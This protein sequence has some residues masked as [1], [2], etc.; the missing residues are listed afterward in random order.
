M[1]M[2]L[3]R[4][5]D[6]CAIVSFRWAFAVFLLCC[7]IGGNA[8][9]PDQQKTQPYQKEQSRQQQQQQKQQPQQH[10]KQHQKQRYEI[11][12]QQTRQLKTPLELFKSEDVR[13]LPGIFKDAEQTDLKYMLAMEPDRLL[14]P[15]LR[16]AA[17]TPKAASYPNWEN[18]GLDGHMGGHYLTALSLMYAATGDK[19]IGARINYM[20]SE[21]KRCQDKNGN[22]YIGG[23]PGGN[24]LW[25][26]VANG[27]I[28]A[29]TF[30]LNKKW[31]PLYNI[32]KIYGGLRDVYLY[33]GNLEAKAMLV[34]YSD[35]FLWLTAKLS[36]QQV[37]Q[38]LSSEH[39]GLNEVFADVYAITGNKK[40]L[41]LAYKF[42][43]HAILEP[44]AAGKD[45]LNGM[46]A[47]TQIPKIIGFKRIAD[48]NKDSLY[49]AAAKF[50]WQ[51]VVNN[52]SVANG[53]NSVREHF[54]PANDFSSMISSVEGPETC[55]SYN[56]L[57]LT[58]LFYT[59][60][61]LP[62]YVDYYERTLYNHILSTQHPGDGG[63]VYFTPMRPG[64][65]RVYSQPQTSFWCCVGSG[66]EN[67]GKYNELIYAHHQDNLYLNLF[68]PSSLI[69][70]EK[71][72]TVAQ[73]T[74][75]PE[76]DQTTFTVVNGK[77]VRFTLNVRY[78]S[79]VAGGALQLVLNGKNVKVN[80]QPGAYATITRIW[81]KGD[82][83][84]VILPMQTRTEQLP[85]S[86]KYVAVMHGPVL[87][88]AKTD[89]ADL[90]GLYAD[91]SRMGHI[92]KGKQYPLQDMPLFVT[93]DKAIA[94]HIQAIPDKKLSYSAASLIYPA[95]YKNLELIPFYKIHD[96][97]YVV[98]WQQESTA[99]L[100]QMRKVQAA[101]EQ[102]KER[103]NAMTVDLVYPGEQQPE[104]DHFVQSEQ[105]TNGTYKDRHWRAAKGWFSYEL[106]NK[107]QRANT[108]RITYYGED[109]NRQFK[110]LLNDSE[111][112]TVT[113]DGS[114]GDVFYNQDYVIPKNLLTSAGPKMTV[115]FVAENGA[116]TAG[117]YEVRLIK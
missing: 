62:S 23:V 30:D 60:D 63:F 104:S 19:R 74:N 71:G 82:R 110:I 112:A 102:A 11:C 99:G 59:S 53:G 96:S 41:A 45:Q 107:G 4:N 80:A 50:F 57:K 34:K 21:L 48:L 61:G 16:E 68:I 76:T 103:L 69:W 79:W 98:Y 109:K 90:T 46:H 73:Q 108:L 35:W 20:L 36:D 83:V 77:A 22:G 86:S 117:I 10:Q 64:H 29:G 113:L 25:N 66:L 18:T 13:L 89:T 75:F 27:K 116:E 26:D 72:I 81:K 88:A 67:H 39:G 9:D 78:P 38:M 114:K 12:Q 6:L 84:Q 49:N 54:N 28:Q 97:R 17:L 5:R 101:E 95:R 70:K 111:I 8:Q 40:Y 7:N 55:N 85:D 51:T 33:T 105:S 31:V 43:H 37:Q 44:L 87:L 47:N 24:A 2:F 3:I 56:M 93:D 94:S 15:Y 42:S 115:K 92:A 52:R 65:Y 32:H 91:D 58:K 1:N 14:A 100:A 106:N